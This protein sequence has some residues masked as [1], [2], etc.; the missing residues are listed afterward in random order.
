MK[1]LKTVKKEIRI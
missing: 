1:V